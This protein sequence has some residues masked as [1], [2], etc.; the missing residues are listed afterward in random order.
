MHFILTECYCRDAA[1]SRI[2]QDRVSYLLLL[3]NEIWKRILEGKNHLADAVCVYGCVSGKPG[4]TAVCSIP[5]CVFVLWDA[6]FRHF[7]LF[8][9][10]QL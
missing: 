5:L 3:P 4:V 2:I 6:G 9:L 10:P 7:Q 1:G 8:V